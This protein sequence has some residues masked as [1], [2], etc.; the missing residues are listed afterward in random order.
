MT[1]DFTAREQE[2]VNADPSFQLGK[3]NTS[4]SCPSLI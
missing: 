4:Y 1:K 2:R 3:S